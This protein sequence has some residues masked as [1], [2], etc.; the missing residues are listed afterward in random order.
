MTVWKRQVLMRHR[1]R[2]MW[3]RA[4]CWNVT[5]NIPLALRVELAL[6]QLNAM[7]GDSAA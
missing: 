7:L 2:L 5:R 1:T 6:Q 3:H 4:M